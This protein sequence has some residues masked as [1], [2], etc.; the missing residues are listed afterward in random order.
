MLPMLCLCVAGC[1]APPPTPAVKATPMPGVPGGAGR[2]LVYM[3]PAPILMGDPAWK[4]RL[5][6]PTEA[7]FAAGGRQ[8][9]ANTTEWYS[10]GDPVAVRVDFYVGVAPPGDGRVVHTGQVVSTGGVLAVWSFDVDYTVP[11]PSGRYAATVRIF[12]E[13]VPL[14]ATAFED[15]AAV[16]EDDSVERYE[17]ELTPL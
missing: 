16:F 12:N 4:T 6:P 5:S 9:D 15:E 17:V 7:D 2:L 10:L 1:G 14:P 3:D 8:L 11:V 13:G